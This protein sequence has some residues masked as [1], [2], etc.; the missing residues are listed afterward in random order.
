MSQTEFG[1]MAG[2]YYSQDTVAMWEAGQVPHALVLLRI[3]DRAKA[4]GANVSVDSILRRERL[5][6][7]RLMIERDPPQGQKRPPVEK[8]KSKRR[9]GYGLRPHHPS[10]N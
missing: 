3:A 9:P 7:A 10:G 1:K 2:D 5:T 6:V 8:E 4:K